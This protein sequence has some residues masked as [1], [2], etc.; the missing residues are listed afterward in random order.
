MTPQEEERAA[1]QKAR[2]L[3]KARRARIRQAAARRR[4]APRRLATIEREME[5]LERQRRAALRL[6]EPTLPIHREI[7]RLGEEAYNLR[8][9]V[10]A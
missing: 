9:G 4:S 1:R 10:A 6:G 8:W 5:G 3:A 2:S 7:Q